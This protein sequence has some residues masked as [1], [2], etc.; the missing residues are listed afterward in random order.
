MLPLLLCLG[1][2]LQYFLCCMKVSFGIE[3]IILRQR[4]LQHRFY[5]LILDAPEF[6]VVFQ[7]QIRLLLLP[8]T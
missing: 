4:Q 8:I 3:N 6:R 1:S 7:R 5:D 2:V